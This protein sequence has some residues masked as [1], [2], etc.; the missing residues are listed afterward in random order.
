M[1]VECSLPK[2]IFGN[3]FSELS[4]K[5]FPEVVEQLKDMINLTLRLSKIPMADITTEQIESAQI[6]RL[7]VGKN[8]PFYSGV[9]PWAIIDDF[10]L[11]RIPKPKQFS[12][13]TYSGGGTQFILATKKT[14]N[15]IYDKIAELK[16][17][18]SRAS[19]QLEK[20]G[21]IQFDLLDKLQANKNL[22]IVRVESQIKDAAE[23]RRKLKRVGRDGK[24]RSFKTIFSSSLSRD[25]LKL[26][27][28]ELVA[29]LPEDRPK[30]RAK[31]KFREFS[32][33]DKRPNPLFAKIGYSELEDEVGDSFSFREMVEG[34]VGYENARNLRERYGGSS[35]KPFHFKE[36]QEIAEAIN[37]MKPIDIEEVI[38]NASA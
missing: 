14:R 7:D 28:D 36:I 20:D 24:D 6:S 8:I 38:R 23:L 22:S 12:I 9:K 1:R 27:F 37:E 10:K 25:L 19:G 26:F 21:W 13:I 4:D 31:D 17:E 34:V 32:K 11:A 5:D 35:V 29:G 2:L 15:I 16:N 18:K 3:N 30:L 33:T